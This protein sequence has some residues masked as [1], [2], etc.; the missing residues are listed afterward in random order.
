[1]KLTNVPHNEIT[2][3][4]G[5]GPGSIWYAQYYGCRYRGGSGALGETC[6]EPNCDGAVSCPWTPVPEAGCNSCSTAGTTSYDYWYCSSGSLG[7]VTPT[8]GTNAEKLVC[9]SDHSRLCVQGTITSGPN[10][11]DQVG[12]C[13][14]GSACSYLSDNQYCR[15][16]SDATKSCAP[17]IDPAT[18]E[19]VLDRLVCSTERDSETATACVFNSA[20]WAWEC[21]EKTVGS[22]CSLYNVVGGSASVSEAKT[23]VEIASEDTACDS[24]FYP[25]D[26]IHRYN[27]STVVSDVERNISYYNSLNKL[28]MNYEMCNRDSDIRTYYLGK[29]C[30]EA[31]NATDMVVLNLEIDPATTRYDANS[32]EAWYTEMAD[33]I[34]DYSSNETY[35]YGKPIVVYIRSM[36]NA[37]SFNPEKFM[38]VLGLN[39]ER[40]INAGV[41]AIQFEDWKKPTVDGTNVYTTDSTGYSSLLYPF[42]SSGK[43]TQTFSALSELGKAISKKISFPVPKATPIYDEASCLNSTIPCIANSACIGPGDVASKGIHNITCYNETGAVKIVYSM[44]PSADQE[45]M[46][47]LFSDPEKYRNIISSVNRFSNWKICNSSAANSTYF[48]SFMSNAGYGIPVAWDQLQNQTCTATGLTNAE[49]LSFVTGGATNYVCRFE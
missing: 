11:G 30:N 43:P 15:E 19:E 37:T 31:F 46:A 1:V 8:S 22:T 23:K 5:Y 16:S 10:A 26:F 13:P 40:M 34:V 4:A 42:D 2:C 27:S 44:T 20:S 35:T 41:V 28:G 3:N 38:T 9:S 48:L 25:A 6:T 7:C 39:M 14:T 45:D 32:Y 47:Q 29:G 24:R 36:K 17:W 12:V 18:G 49:T 21:P 33:A